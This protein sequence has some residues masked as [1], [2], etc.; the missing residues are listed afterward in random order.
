MEISLTWNLVLAAILIMLIAYNFLLGQNATIKLALSMYIAILTADGVAR[1]LK[2]FVF[3]MSPGFQSLLGEH[4]VGIFTAI[5]LGLFLTA[6]VI[7]VV[8]G[9][10]HIHLDKH[11][12]WAMRSVLEATFATLSSALFL[13]TMLIVHL[14]PF[15]EGMIHANEISI[16]NESLAACE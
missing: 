13:S 10:F 14:Y 1:M 2:E 8:K 6:A 4:E 16:Y 5:R 12:H 9:G 7:F 15:V 3:D 11:E